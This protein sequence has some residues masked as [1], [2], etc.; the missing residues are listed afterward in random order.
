VLDR[1]GST[2]ALVIIPASAESI[3]FL[4]RRLH[5]DLADYSEY[6]GSLALVVP[7]PVLRLVQH[8]LVPGQDGAPE[9]L[10]YRLVPRAG[11][12]LADLSLT[13]LER[14][15]NLLSR[16]ET[17][18]VPGDGLVIVPCTLPVQ[19]SGYVVAHPI[20]GVLAYQAPLPFIRS[21]QIDFGVVGRQVRVEAPRSDSPRSGT[22]SYNVAE[23]SHEHP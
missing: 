2:V 17:V 13:I 21:V 6:L 4:K 11:Q 5:V 7:D 20:H 12:T 10:V 16:F 8:F 3:G 15:A 23:V 22:T 9:R 19:A 14:R 1:S 18:A